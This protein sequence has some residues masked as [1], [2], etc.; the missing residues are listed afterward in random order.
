MPLGPPN[1]HI[2]IGWVRP[3]IFSLLLLITVA[4]LKTVI[5]KVVLSAMPT[6]V[7]YSL[8][9]AVMT[10]LIIC[11]PAMWYAPRGT[12]MNCVPSKDMWM[13]AFVAIA[14]AVDLGMSNI[15][16]SLL[17]LPLQQA[18][19]SVIPAATILM[20]SLVF[21]RL[22][23]CGQYVAILLLCSGASIGHLDQRTRQRGHPNLTSSTAIGELAMLF[24][25]LAAATK[26][27]FAKA[28]IVAWKQR[29][30]ALGLLL[31]IEVLIACVLLPW[32]LLN[33]ELSE[34][35]RRILQSNDRLSELAT[36]CACAAFGGFRFFCE[37]YVLK[38][39]SATTLSATNLVAHSFIIVVSI[40]VSNCVPTLSLI[41]GTLLTIAGAWLF[42]HLKLRTERDDSG[43]GARVGAADGDAAS[44]GVPWKQGEAAASHGAPF[45]SSREGTGCLL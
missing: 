35:H 34:F 42:A 21:R 2:L 40:L 26:Y 32:A 1:E 18:I 8:L 3:Q 7:A 39:W 29:M 11:G 5:T 41:V 36:L 43:T 30:G 38:F 24:A 23:P 45:G 37:L 20:E 14:V 33:G 15:A 12:G 22:K 25:I 6:P 4:A 19:A 10:A 31:W 27:V 44:R 28:S 16:I 9:S 13:L 17:A